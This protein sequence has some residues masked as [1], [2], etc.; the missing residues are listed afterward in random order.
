[1]ITKPF[2]I[3]KNM[4]NDFEAGFRAG[5]ILAGY[6][7]DYIDNQFYR[8]VEA[9]TQMRQIFWEYDSVEEGNLAIDKASEKAEKIREEG[10]S[11]FTKI[12]EE[13]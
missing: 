7:K 2:E 5:L 9:P 6:E 1:M 3:E 10:M 13:E 11:V 12:T 8:T 4:V